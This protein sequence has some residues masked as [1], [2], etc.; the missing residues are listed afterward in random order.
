[1]SATN[2]LPVPPQAFKG[3]FVTP[4]HADYTD[5]LSRWALNAR[6]NAAVVAFVKDAEDI[7]LVIEY[8]RTHK[9]P[10]A[11]RGGGHS[12]AGASSIK[13][14]LVIDLSRYLNG[15]RIDAENH[16][17]YVDGGA[18]WKTV[19]KAAIEHGLATVAGTVN[20]VSLEL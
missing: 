12:V 14:G 9:F 4:T 16:L 5:A 19:D 7:A 10:I 1:M 18:I 15:C 11:I 13:D 6:R 20:D 17:A 2:S 8:A 3:D